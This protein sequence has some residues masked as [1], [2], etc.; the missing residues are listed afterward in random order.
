[1]FGLYIVLGLLV[2]DIG[3]KKTQATLF[4]YNEGINSEICL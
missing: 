4:L 3:K 1:M 2:Y